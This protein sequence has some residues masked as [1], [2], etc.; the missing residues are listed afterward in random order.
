MNQEIAKIF[1]EI[2]E[3]LEMKEM[4]FKPRAYQKAAQS[5]QGL[6][7]NVKTIFEKKGIKG[8]EEISGVGEGIAERIVEYIKK[9]KIKGY[10]KLKKE[11]PVNISELVS[12][13]G[14]GPKLIKLFYE[15]LKVRNIND[16][17]KAARHGKISTLPRCGK[18]LEQ[19]ILQ[20]IEFYKKS[21]ERFLLGDVFEL[22]EKIK[23]RL[24]ELKETEK[25]E[26]AGSF[27]RKKETIGDLDIL[28]V[29]EKPKK[30][31]D[32]FV[33][34]PEVR[35]VY[36]K[37]LKKTMV[38]LSN[39]LDVDLRV[40]DEKS[41]G[42]ALQY[43]TGNKAHNIE[44]RKIALKKKYK[45][46]EYG[47]FKVG[48]KKSEV[49]I[50]GQNEKEIYKKLGLQ[51]MPPE[52]RETRENTGEIELAQ[53]NKLSEFI[54]EKDIKG[55]LHIHSHWKV[56]K[57]LIKERIKKAKE[58][59][60]EYL[61]ISDHTKF[62]AIEHGLNEQDL[63]KQSKEIERF[64]LHV[65][66]FKILHGCEANILTDGSIDIDDKVLSK[67]DYVIAGVHSQMKMSKEKMTERIITAMKN[68][69]V[70]II[71]H[72][73]GRVIQRREEYEIDFDKI[74]RV[75]KETGTILEINA[76]P[77]RLDLND[78]KIRKAKEFG[79]KMIISSDAHQNEQM[80]LMKFGVWQARRGWAEKK[81][82]VNTMSFKEISGLFK[83]PKK[84]RF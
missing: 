75:A 18:K 16:L 79:V 47:L 65:S 84:K 77:V 12:I 30:V 10:E 51:F 45:L 33:S 72:L 34:M 70:D 36:G 21:H 26:A 54:E 13:E 39:G 35:H 64:R 63:L 55:D 22:A 19:K 23:S 52:T 80:D 6:D 8:L 62:L 2:A 49:R 58:L 9:G 32:F 7:E 53:K 25:I 31:M 27:R 82:I 15:K 14:V 20:G 17:E 71:A 5:I 60:Y 76:N 59:G 24:S 69:H 61:G 66:G 56:K 68:P 67:L 42:S 48:S 37:G 44:L 40:V 81:D 41:F 50:A 57:G 74:L 43:F 83:K 38:R 46:N 78:V 29:S 4:A 73:T 28:V 3:I 11:M 1:Y